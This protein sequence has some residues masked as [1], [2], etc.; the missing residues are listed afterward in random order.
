M[1]PCPSLEL[2]GE[3][4]TGVD[5]DLSID[6]VGQIGGPHF[7][8]RKG[9][10]NWCETSMKH[11]ILSTPSNSWR[12]FAIG[13]SLPISMTQSRTLSILV[14]STSAS[15]KTYMLSPG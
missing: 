11:G 3:R 12:S 5:H 7:D 15:T 14:R 9:K 4:A 10:W 2:Q 8:T 6:D 13:G 1:W